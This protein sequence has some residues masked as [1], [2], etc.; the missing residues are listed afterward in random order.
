M[1]LT[2]VMRLM[3][4]KLKFSAALVL[5][6]CGGAVHAKA[7]PDQIKQLNG[8]KLNCIGAERAGTA[9]GVAAYTGK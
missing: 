2:N 7:T 5:A 9:G 3:R 1:L 8:D 6:L 4:V